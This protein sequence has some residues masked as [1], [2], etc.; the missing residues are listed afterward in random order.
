VKR[1]LL[2]AAAA[3][4][5]ATPA[6]ADT[7]VG[8]TMAL[9]DDNFLTK[10]REAIKAQADTQKGVHVQFEDAQADIGRQ[11]NQV[12]NFIAQKV[13]AIIVNPADT[14]ATKKITQMA[15]GAGI[16][17]VYVN[18]GP[19]QK[20]LPPK[21]SVVVSDH[22][23]A[24]RMEMDEL[25]KCMKGKGNAAIMLGELASN[26]TDERTAGNK[27]VIAKHPDIKVVQEQT[28]NYQRNQ[29][30][31]LMNNWITNGVKFDAVAANN[32]EMAIGAIFAMQ[33]AG[34]DPKTK[35]VG[36]IDATA[37]A[38]DQ[39][40]KGNLA[41]TVFQ[42]AKGQGRGAIEAAL[43]LVKGEKVDSFVMIPYELVTPENMKSYENR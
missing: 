29:A 20:Q 6:L 22:V 39:M 28:A 36:G 9:F 13:D 42:D 38:L 4:S 31:D 12:Q 14:A 8:V 24:G 19:D 21:V 2:A 7:N 3:V 32:D 17:L 33:Q 23:V 15:T 30:I 18:R 37:D 41:V 10:I 40:R 26:A 5:I 27:E 43:K 34:V 1:I 35:C 25:A 11:I 16:P